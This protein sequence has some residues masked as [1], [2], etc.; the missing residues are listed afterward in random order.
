MN[1][2]ELVQR[3]RNAVVQGQRE[4]FY[5]PVKDNKP[6]GDFSPMILEVE[7]SV[8]DGRVNCRF[9]SYNNSCDLYAYNVDEK[10]IIDKSTKF[11]IIYI[12]Y[13]LTNENGDK[14]SL[15]EFKSILREMY[16]E[17]YNVYEDIALIYEE[18]DPFLKIDWGDGCIE[19]YSAELNLKTSSIQLL[20]TTY[21]YNFIGNTGYKSHTYLKSGRYEIKIYANLPSLYGLRQY[22]M[23]SDSIR[24]K[25]LIKWGNLHLRVPQQMFREA[26]SYE[27]IQPFSELINNELY[28]VFNCTSMFDGITYNIQNIVGD[29]LI[30]L[31]NLMVASYMFNNCSFEQIPAN[32]FQYNVKLQNVSQIFGNNYLLTSVG[33]GVFSNL[34]YLINV[35][36]CFYMCE[37]LETV[38]NSLFENDVNLQSVMSVFYTYNSHLKS[39]GDNMC[40]NCFSMTQTGN[41]FYYCSRLKSVGKNMFE[42]CYALKSVRDLFENCISLETVGTGLFK[43]CYNICEAQNL[44][45]NCM[46]VTV[47]DRL[48]YDLKCDETNYN[49]NGYNSYYNK[50]VRL[51]CQNMFYS[52]T[53]FT[54]YVQ[55]PENNRVEI[56]SYIVNGNDEDL[57]SEYY[58]YDFDTFPYITLGKEMF[59]PQ[60]I[61]DLKTY[62]ALIS[63]TSFQSGAIRHKY[64]IDDNHYQSVIY[65]TSIKGEAFPIWE[66]PEVFS[67]GQGVYGYTEMALYYNDSCF[68]THKPQ[69]DNVDLIPLP[70]MYK[71]KI[72][73]NNGDGYGY[74]MSSVYE[75]NRYEFIYLNAVQTP[76]SACISWSCEFEEVEN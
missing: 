32:F 20:N 74:T 33:N 22:D 18:F 56:Y 46:K 13:N 52:N 68:L 66:N 12:M 19:D 54:N 4:M 21:S 41:T 1:R 27:Y 15:Q 58:S 30:N 8:E 10:G 47:P 53:E 50:N 26:D 65:S 72:D 29:S 16:S 64:M 28:Y 71:Y 48:F 55:S 42:N 25:K 14:L 45:Y 49:S 44:F 69:L 67:C 39:V 62:N 40:K 70:K 51:N 37:K 5:C 11:P 9:Y 35:T 57:K 6:K 43:N 7:V 60:F 24:V 76:S 75:L 36:N 31:P 61:S 73:Y 17:E 59:S 63:M 38:G 34:P 23:T 3:W 2:K